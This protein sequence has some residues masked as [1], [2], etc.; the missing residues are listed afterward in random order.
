MPFPREG[1]EEAVAPRNSRRGKELVETQ[2]PLG[3]ARSS[4][5]IPNCFP[6]RKEKKFDNAEAFSKCLRV[7]IPAQ[8]PG[9]AHFPPPP[10]TARGSPGAGAA[11]SR[12]RSVMDLIC[13][14]LISPEQ[15]RL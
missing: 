4:S 2:P 1:R 12:G 14:L 5:G 15:I 9:G 3:P 8:A 13:D 7:L 11:G 6:G 10:R